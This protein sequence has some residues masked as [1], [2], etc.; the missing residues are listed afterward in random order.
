M[1]PTSLRCAFSVQTWVGGQRQLG[2]SGC[3]GVMAGWR[4][5]CHMEARSSGCSFP[6]SPSVQLLE[7][8]SFW[9][10]AGSPGSGVR[11]DRV[12]GGRP[13]LAGEGRLWAV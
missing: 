2:P 3:P 6:E 7:L 12:K 1:P 11:W 13:L 8:R 5:C 10:R 4:V 9:D